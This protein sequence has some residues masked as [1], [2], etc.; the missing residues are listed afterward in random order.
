MPDVESTGWLSRL[1]KALGGV[2][3]GAVMFFGSFP[4]LLWNEHNAVATAKSLEEGAA[5][6]LDVP[7]DKVDDANEGKLV[8]VSGD[9]TTAE[10]LK[11]DLFG[12]SASALKLARKVEIYQWEERTEKKNEKK[13]GG[14]EVT[15]TYRTTTTRSGS[16]NP[17]T[18]AHVS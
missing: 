6:C 1:G 3:I 12:V 14:R 4:L 10:T 13:V 15:K 9:A 5:A 18:P 16:R 11:D 7:A 8:H 17:S 2:L